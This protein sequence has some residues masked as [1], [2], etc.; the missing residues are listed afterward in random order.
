MRVLV[1]LHGRG[2]GP[3]PPGATALR[4]DGHDSWAD[5]PGLATGGS[6]GPLPRTMQRVL[7]GAQHAH[8]GLEVVAQS[9]ASFR[10]L[11]RASVTAGPRSAGSKPSA[12]PRTGGISLWA[13]PSRY[14]EPAPE[15][16]ALRTSTHVASRSTIAAGALP[17]NPGTPSR[18][19]DSTIHSTLNQATLCLTNEDLAGD[20]PQRRR[21]LP[22]D[23]AL[24]PAHFAQSH[25]RG[26]QRRA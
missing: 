13:L 21:F 19:T 25:C 14:A 24:R 1:R 9:P 18:T 23:T 17:I 15:P 7:R 2:R 12:R 4:Q 16:A 22:G 20:R 26:G 5:Q 3:P 10:Q 6:T 8:M 11:A